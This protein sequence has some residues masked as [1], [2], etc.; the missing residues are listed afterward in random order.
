MRQYIL[1]WGL[2][3][4]KWLQWRFYHYFIFY[5]THPKGCKRCTWC[6]Y[7]VPRYPC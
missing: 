6:G 1:L 7:G 2:R 4:P 3:L 5:C